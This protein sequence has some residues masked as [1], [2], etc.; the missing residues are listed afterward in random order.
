MERQN[1]IEWLLLSPSICFLLSLSPP[2]FLYLFICF[3][4]HPSLSVYL[5]ISLSIY[6]VLFFYQ[7]IISISLQ[8]MSTCS[9]TLSLYFLSYLSSPS[10]GCHGCLNVFRPQPNIDFSLEIRDMYGEWKKVNFPHSF[11]LKSLIFLNTP[12]YGAGRQPWGKLTNNKPNK[13]TATDLYDKRYDDGLFEI[14]GINSNFHLA[15][16]MGQFVDG[17]RIGQSYEAK[18]T[19]NK[20]CYGQIDGEPFI[21]PAAIYH[22]RPLK[23][24]RMLTKIDSI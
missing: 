10:I 11:K 18:L 5:S 22:I 20:L 12:T 4:L 19:I 2:L 8:S 1:G 9:L 21:S 7:S 3:P 24:V 23:P 6:D 16:V 14:I 15:F 17:V 13:H